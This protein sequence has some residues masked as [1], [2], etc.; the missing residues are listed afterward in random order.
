MPLVEVHRVDHHELFLIE[1]HRDH[2]EGNPL[3]I[4]SEESNPL[5]HTRGCGIPT[6]L[7]E[8]DAAAR[9][10]VQRA[11]PRDPVLGG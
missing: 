4:V 3:E 11:L 1:F 9:D 7:D 5:V 10:D 8:L 2:L 6:A